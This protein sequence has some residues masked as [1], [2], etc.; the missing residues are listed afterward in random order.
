MAGCRRPCGVR[1]MAWRG[2]PTAARE[3]SSEADLGDRGQERHARRGRDERRSTYGPAAVWRWTEATGWRQRG[4]IAPDAAGAMLAVAVTASGFVA[5]GQNGHDD[6]ALAWTSA[7]GLSWTAAPD[8]PGSTTSRHRSGC[9][10]WSPVR[11]GWWRAAGG[12]MPGTAR[13]STWTSAD[14]VTWSGPAWEP[15]FSGGQITGLSV[16]SG[17][18]VAVGRTGY[19]GQQPG[20]D[21]GER[22]AVTGPARTP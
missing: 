6:G 17:G 14:G 16:G 3:P 10:P 12:R 1:M 13:R 20:R 8:Q 15:L 4:T 9:S 5:V 19:P 22:R 18:L 7:D 2:T 11:P 21:L